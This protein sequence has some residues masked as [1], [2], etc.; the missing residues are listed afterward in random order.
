MSTP[1]AAKHDYRAPSHRA[2]A[3]AAPAAVT[4]AH[5][6]GA[7]K[8]VNHATRDLV[9]IVIAAAGSG[10]SVNVFGACSPTP[11]NWGV[12][13][14]IAYAASVSSNPAVAF[15][16]EYS[17]SFASVTV[18]GHLHEKHLLVETFTVFTDGSGRSNLYTTDQMAK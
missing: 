14:G 15:C 2:E 6:I 13:P 3:G 4:P 10:I 5:L 17:F 16:A 9:E 11:C 7:W 1:A 8:N 18:L 12:A